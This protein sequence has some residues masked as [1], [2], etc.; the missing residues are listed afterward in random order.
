M[1]GHVV[2]LL[3]K[4]CSVRPDTKPPSDP[5][6]LFECYLRGRLF[7][8]G[9]TQIAVGDRV[10]FDP[11]DESHA[12]HHPEENAPERGVIHE[13]LPRRTVLIRPSSAGGGRG[14]PP[15]VVAANVDQT[16]V[17]AAFQ[18]PQ[19]KTGLIDRYL[20]IAHRAGI[21]PAICLNKWDLASSEDQAKAHEDLKPYERLGIPIVFTS[22]LS[23]KGI[24]ELRGLLKGK[25]SVFVGH[26]GVGKSKLAGA[27]QP[28]LT[29][30]SSS[31]SR[32]GKGRHTT[33]ASTLFSL[34]FGG[35]LVDTPGIRELGITDLAQEEIA[36]HFADFASFLGHCRFKSCSH[37]PEPGCA[38]QQAVESGGIYQARYDSYV[39]LYHELAHHHRAS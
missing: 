34:D 25:R 3:G 8:T 33:S 31:V 2:K 13:I 24:E 22:S 32:R 21:A 12:L 5:D 9:S 19:Y 4:S 35:E 11:V 15:Q 23:G 18:Q 36:E 28:G 38:V 26:S 27:V 1:K 16:V 7:E 17:V 37:I 14:K 6:R 10:E 29:L 39:K 30:T 20:V